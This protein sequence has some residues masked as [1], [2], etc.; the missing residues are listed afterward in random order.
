MP[1][2]SG[3][4]VVRL[5]GG[6]SNS[7][8]NAA[9]GGAKSSNT[10]STSTDGLFDTVS[11]AEASAGDT[12]YRCVYLHNA[13]ASSSMIDAV[14]WVGANT[15]NAS[16]TLDIGVGTAAVNGTEQTVANEST[17]PT[18]VSF[19]AP[20]SQ[21]AGLALGTIP[22]GQHKAIWLRRTVSASAPASSNDTWQLN[23]AADYTS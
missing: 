16:T 19:S 18:S 15:P 3:D 9:L 11:S 23:F 14:I 22:A 21:G 10:A 8:G 17:A 1:L 6:A 7:D 12:E 5:S 13:N 20:S 4:F 2:V